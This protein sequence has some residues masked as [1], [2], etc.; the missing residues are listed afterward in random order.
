MGWVGAWGAWVGWVMSKPRRVQLR[1]LAAVC[2]LLIYDIECFSSDV[3]ME[4]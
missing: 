1:P 3:L 4:N 2:K